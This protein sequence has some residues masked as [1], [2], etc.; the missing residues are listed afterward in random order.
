[1][2]CPVSFSSLNI[3]GQTAS[4]SIENHRSNQIEIAKR[5][6]FRILLSIILICFSW[7][8]SLA[9]FSSHC[10]QRI[11]TRAQ[12][13]SRRTFHSRPKAV[14]K[15]L[16]RTP[17]PVGIHCAPIACGVEC[18]QIKLVTRHLSPI[19]SL[20]TH[21]TSWRSVPFG[22]TVYFVLRI[23]QYVAIV[24]F[25]SSPS[26]RYIAAGNCLGQVSS[27][28]KYSTEKQDMESWRWREME[29]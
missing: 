19:S 23:R 27:T 20:I 21:H 18:A 24:D 29:T 1:M 26:I 17:L 6:C 4:P 9:S 12:D 16:M 7:R 15:C 8:V 14:W 13:M 22:E 5:G 2:Q 11:T 10:I 25:D 28:R 3:N